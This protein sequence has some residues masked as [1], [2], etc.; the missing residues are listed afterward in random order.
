M[1]RKLEK[2]SQRGEE[3]HNQMTDAGTAIREVIGRMSVPALLLLIRGDTEREG[4]AILQDLLHLQLGAMTPGEEEDIEEEK[5]EEEEE[6]VIRSQEEIEDTVHQEAALT[7]EMRREKEDQNLRN[8][9]IVIEKILTLKRVLDQETQAGR[10]TPQRKAGDQK[11]ATRD[12][13][14][15]QKGKRRGAEAETRARREEGVV[16]P[17]LVSK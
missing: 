2:G 9:N 10:E 4:G 14:V 6:I 1:W 13:N 5:E 16:H 11:G 3:G 17:I 12:Q 7:Q 8:L 15:S